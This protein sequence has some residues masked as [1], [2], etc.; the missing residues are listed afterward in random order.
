[1]GISLDDITIRPIA[2]EDNAAIAKVIRDTLAEFGANHPGTVYFD[3]TTDHLWEMFQAAGS[4]YQVALLNGKIVGGGGIF[5]SD[6]LPT[7]TCELVKMYLL[8]EVR[9]IG[10]G[11]KLISDC[12]TTAE[13]LG[14]KNIY[15]ETMPELKDAL[16][17]YAK[18]GFSYLKGP[19]GNTGHFG[20]ALWMLKNL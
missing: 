14:Y 10:L 20:C 11:R 4:F 13:K 16:N 6:G 7:D 17:T 5:P 8:P 9:G 18:F 19:M 15:L 1:M 2:P 12:I 3:P